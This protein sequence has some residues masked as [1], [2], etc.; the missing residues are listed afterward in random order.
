MASASS[1][2]CQATSMTHKLRQQWAK[3]HHLD[4]QERARAST[5]DNTQMPQGFPVAT[6][7]ETEALGSS[8]KIQLKTDTT[9]M[10]EPQKNNTGLMEKFSNF[11]RIR[12]GSGDLERVRNNSEESTTSENGE[13]AEV[14]PGSGRTRYFSENSKLT[15]D[16]TMDNSLASNSSKS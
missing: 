15:G 6:G 7:P 11:L 8:A 14:V 12:R 10:V 2:A 5:L 13:N 16:F 9:A 1:V 4:A 3:K